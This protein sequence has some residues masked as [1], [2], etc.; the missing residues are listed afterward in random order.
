MIVLGSQHIIV[1]QQPNRYAMK[2]L[3]P[4][5]SWDMTAQQGQQ[6]L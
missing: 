2:Q 4:G 6:K 5:P 3:M 1:N